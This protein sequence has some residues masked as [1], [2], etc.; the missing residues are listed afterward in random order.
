MKYQ[1]TNFLKGILPAILFFGIIFSG[2]TYG[3]LNINTSQTA[4]QM[5][6]ALVGNGYTYMNA[7]LNCPSGAFG[8]FTNGATTNLGIDQG[9]MLT[10]GSALTAIGPNISTSSGISNGGAGDADLTALGGDA[11]FDACVLEFDVIPICDTLRFEFVFGSEEYPEYSCGNVNDVF[12]FFVSGPGITGAQNI[13]LVPSTLIPI[14]INTINAFIADGCGDATLDVS[15]C[16]SNTA[17][18][19]NNPGGA[20]IEYD[21]FTQVLP[22]EIIV[23]ACSTYHVKL[24][25]ADGGDGVWDSGVFLRRGTLNCFGVSIVASTTGSSGIDAVEEC[26]DGL[27]QMCLSNPQS[28]PFT[29]Y[30]T[31]GGSATSGVDYGAFPDSIVF[32]ADSSCV[33]VPVSPTIDGVTEG[34]ETIMLFYTP[35]MCASSDTAFI[36]ILDLYTVNA[37]PDVNYCHG[38]SI[39]IGPP[40]VPGT[41]YI[42]TPGSS[43]LS[44]D[45]INQP[46][47]LLN[48]PSTTSSI[49]DVFYLTASIGGCSNWDSV[50]VTINPIPDPDAGTDKTICGGQSAVIGG[51][52]VPGFTYSWSPPGGVADPNAAFTSVT[53]TN[54]TASPIVVEKIVT[55]SIQGCEG[56]DT[57]NITVLSAPISNAGP[58]AAICSGESTVI[59]TPPVAGYAYL[60]SPTTGLSNSVIP[61]PQFNETTPGTYTFHLSAGWLSCSDIDTVV[62]LVKPLPEPQAGVDISICPDSPGALG[63]PNQTG[64]TYSWSPATGVSDPTA[65]APSIQLS[66]NTSDMLN[67][68]MTLT[69][70]LAGCMGTD[71]VKVT[72]RPTPIAVIERDMDTICVDEFGFASYAG[73]VLENPVYTWDFNSPANQSGLDAGPVSASWNTLGT[74]R[75]T[76]MVTEHGCPSLPDTTELVVID[77][78]VAPDNVF[79]PDGDGNNDHFYIVNVERNPNSDLKIFNRWGKLVYH[80]ESYQNDWSG[81]ANAHAGVYFYVLTLKDGTA[82]RGFV[83]L[84]K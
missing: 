58:D 35:S 55:G 69:A 14:T 11:T 15:C 22:A 42:W 57:V 78:T 59:G 62:V 7:T 34:T 74:K 82:Q 40:F 3:Q 4:N 52:E 32:P 46:Y 80:S 12:G 13:A 21:G 1:I 6:Q 72:V 47:V 20:T 9:I 45:S 43:G 84:V 53:L 71:G 27:F 30:Y 66:N 36:N 31:I 2:A 16:E 83:T 73:K 77:C 75:I 48:N 37:G 38:D 64:Y 44:N 61:N 67:I 10:S 51:T 33:L 65:S 81:D 63:S 39:Q 76:L 5:V 17:Y 18:Y 49:V 50:I 19:V 60:W 25:I 54:T 29:F 24:A 79:T 23:Q 8:S 28:S 26:Q 41:T 70:N 68:D 56:N